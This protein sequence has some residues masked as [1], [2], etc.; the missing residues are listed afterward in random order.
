[1][2][3]SAAS[4]NL[5]DGIAAVDFLVVPILTLERL[6]AFGHLGVGRRHILWIGITANPTAE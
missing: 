1:L 4:R 3:G 5:A 6:F 2:R